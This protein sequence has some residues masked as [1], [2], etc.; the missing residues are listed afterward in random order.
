MGEKMD[1]IKYVDDWGENSNG[2]ESRWKNHASRRIKIREKKII[3]NNRKIGGK[4][5]AGW[6]RLPRKS[7]QMSQKKKKVT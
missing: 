3:Q 7:I 6:K 1:R 2:Q 4:N 5:H